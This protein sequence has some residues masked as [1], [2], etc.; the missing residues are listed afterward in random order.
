MVGHPRG[1]HVDLSCIEWSHVLVV[2]RHTALEVRSRP[3]GSLTP[4]PVALQEEHAVPLQELSLHLELVPRKIASLWAWARIFAASRAHR[5]GDHGCWT[6]LKAPKLVSMDVVSLG[7]LVILLLWIVLTVNYVSSNGIW[8]VASWVLLFIG[9]LYQRNL[10]L[11]VHFSLSV[12]WL[13]YFH[14]SSLEP[15]CTLLVILLSI[16]E[17]SRFGF[18]LRI[19]NMPPIFLVLGFYLPWWN[20]WGRWHVFSVS[21]CPLNLGIILLTDRNLRVILESIR[22]LQAWLRWWDVVDV[23][24]EVIIFV[25]LSLTQIYLWL[26]AVTQVVFSYKHRKGPFRLFIHALLVELHWSLYMLSAHVTWHFE[27]LRDL[28][29]RKIIVIAHLGPQFLLL[30]FILVVDSCCFCGLLLS[31]FKGHLF[32]FILFCERGNLLFLL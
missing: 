11:V 19:Y 2:R 5:W 31:H 6:F 4:E 25:G 24:L 7:S 18:E 16:C 28:S 1:A 29:F 32:L 30:G 15:S 8:G 3:H 23:S 27:L 17:P 10:G 14:A 22:I 12:G 21:A 20:G 9:L 26:P 13:Y